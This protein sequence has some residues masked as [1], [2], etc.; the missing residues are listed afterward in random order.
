MVLILVMVLIS[1]QSL[2][3]CGRGVRWSIKFFLDG[4]II[5]SYNL[6]VNPFSKDFSSFFLTVHT[7][8][9][10]SALVQVW[11]VPRHSPRLACPP[12]LCVPV[13]VPWGVLVWGGGE[14][15]SSA[16]RRGG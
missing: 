12:A 15:D 14:G 11:R 16:G 10:W 3:A 4:L 2:P 1:F 8:R 5:S 9:A 6:K 7:L 13:R